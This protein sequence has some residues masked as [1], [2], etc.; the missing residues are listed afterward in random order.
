MIKLV[1]AS[2]TPENR[3]CIEFIIIYDSY[4]LRRIAAQKIHL[5]LILEVKCSE[6]Q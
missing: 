3:L 6:S 5:F 1:A 2:L 4:F